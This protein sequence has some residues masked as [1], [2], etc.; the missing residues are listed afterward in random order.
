VR[1]RVTTET[2][3]R[4]PRRAD[5]APQSDAR[6]LEASAKLGRY[7]LV[8]PIARGGMAEVWIARQRSGHGF[9]RDVALK[10]ILPEYAADPSFRAMF[11]EEARL[12]SRIRHSNVVEVID[13][14]DEP[15]SLFLVMALVDGPSLATMMRRWLVRS[16]GR[17][18]PFDVAARVIADV[19]TGLHAA[20]E[21]RDEQGTSLEVVHRDVSPQNI[22]VG[23]DGMARLTDFG[24]AKAFG[25]MVEETS[26]GGGV[27][28]KLGYLS[29]EQA[30]KERLDRRS[31]VYSLGVVLW[32]MLTGTRLL[33]G[34]DVFDTMANVLN[35]IAP[36]PRTIRP[37]VPACL[38]AAAMRALER[39]RDQRFRT[40]LELALALEDACAELRATR[41]SVTSLVADLEREDS[42]RRP[43]PIQASITETPSAAATTELAAGKDVP[44][45]AGSSR[46][47]GAMLL[48][49]A[50]LAATG[51]TAVSL[52]RASHG[53]VPPRAEATVSVAASVLPSVVT[54]S[55]MADPSP[56]APPV[57]EPP[58][59]AASASSRRITPPNGR[60][61]RPR[62]TPKESG[63][64]YDRN[65]YER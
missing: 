38:A 32:E 6:P 21:L 24:I 60:T 15:P 16:P 7:E 28:G 53:D 11:L 45:P 3:L 61:V 59:P 44:P 25:R 64:R 14:I 51:I 37:D 63:P 62:G 58:V 12:A 57:P 33:A 35:R 19:A 36:D 13:I 4:S 49:L 65:P 1:P 55:G 30:R 47:R 5:A 52:R 29:P 23:S 41:H 18:L 40:A 46:A 20:H 56:P 34:E 22:L 43:S 27:K 42:A 10:T 50:I 8:S 2:G 17:G 54:A 26:H 9:S 39:D 48:S 31:D